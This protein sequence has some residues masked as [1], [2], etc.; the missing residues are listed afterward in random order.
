MVT[1]KI[2]CSCGRVLA[3]PPWMG[4]VDTEVRQN[5]C[6]ECAAKAKAED[7]RRRAEGIA[8]VRPEEV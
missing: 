2:V 6:P 4:K 3:T 5:G 1:K 8:A 7:A